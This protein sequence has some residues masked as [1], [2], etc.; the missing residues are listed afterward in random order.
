MVYYLRVLGSF[1]VFFLGGWREYQSKHRLST[2][3]KAPHSYPN[4]GH[5]AFK[6]EE[7]NDTTPSEM[8]VFLANTAVFSW[9]NQRQCLLLLVTT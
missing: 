2:S 6:T 1:L 5:T 8:V 9:L 7:Y 4:V 3:S